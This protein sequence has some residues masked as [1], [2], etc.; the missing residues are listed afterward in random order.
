MEIQQLRGWADVADR[1]LVVS[2]VVALLA[3]VAI[4]ISAFFSVRFAGA[5]RAQEQE[6][7]DRY[8]GQWG[9]HAEQLQQDA[10]QAAARIA[11]LERAVGDAGERADRAGRESANARE[12]TAVLEREAG[13]AKERVATLEKRV[14]ERE[15]RP[16]AATSAAAE[17]DGKPAD[18]AENEK[19]TGIAERL[20]KHA[21][22][23]AA[24]YVIDE[25]PEAADVGASINAILGDAGWTAATWRWS[26]VGGIL[27]VVV[28][29]RSGSEPAVDDAASTL[30]DALRSD[31][32]NAAKATWPADWRRFR[33]TLSHGP[34]TPA[35]T[36]AP[37]RIVIGSKAK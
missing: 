29:V 19:R 13:E 25:V 10:A 7:F 14:E 1:A 32:F 17:P 15:A 18:R 22:M 28:L 8:R 30:V 31:G 35:P 36:D 16:S 12:R 20:A 37:I 23:K 3:V 9:R 21:G 5:I 34:L 33:G 24:V 6:V 27:G 11:E 2:I 26:G 4:G